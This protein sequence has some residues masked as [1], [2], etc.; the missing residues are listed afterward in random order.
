[1]RLRLGSYERDA[2]FIRE[3]RMETLR[4]L[5][6]DP[7]PSLMQFSPMSKY[8]L[9]EDSRSSVPVGLSESAMLSDVYDSYDETPYRDIADLST[10]C[11]F[12]EMAGMRTIFVRRKYR[13][14]SLF[15][16]I[17][18]VSARLFHGF[19]ARFATA[20]TRAGDEY[21]NQLYAKCGG[22][23]VGTFCVDAVGEPSALFVFDI[24]RMLRH[25]VMRRLA[26]QLPLASAELTAAN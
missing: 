18:L 7:H 22:A 23:R 13:A 25:P 19:G 6:L 4:A 11:S 15:M 26:R 14:S 12:S 1:M 24:E 21:L 2:V 16:R 20:S 8:V 3:A 9:A 17:L 5:H 10:Y